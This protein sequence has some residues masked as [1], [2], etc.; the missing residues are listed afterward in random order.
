MYSE[1]LKF[2]GPKTRAWLTSFY[3]EILRSGHL[4]KLFKRAKVI[5]LLKPGKDGLDAAD[6]LPIL[7]L[8]SK[9]Q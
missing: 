8:S 2:S 9:E 7:L 4:P 5:A 6:F 3:S 1:F